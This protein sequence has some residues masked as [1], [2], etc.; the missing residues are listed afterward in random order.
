MMGGGGGAFLHGGNEPQATDVKRKLKTLK[1][2]P[3]NRIM[4]TVN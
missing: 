3:L 1:V 4:Q 2:E